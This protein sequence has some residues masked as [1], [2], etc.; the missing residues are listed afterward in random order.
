MWLFCKSGFFSAVRHQT[1][2]DV[3]HVRARFKGD[4][5]RLLTDYAE[6]VAGLPKPSAVAHTPRA[7]YAYR[8][9]VPAAA[10]TNLVAAVAADIDYTNFKYAAHDGTAR[11]DAYFEVWNAMKTA[12]VNCAAEEILQAAEAEIERRLCLMREAGV[13]T[14]ADLKLPPKIFELRD[15]FLLTEKMWKRMENV[16]LK[17]R[18]AWVAVN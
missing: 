2:A 12:Q 4:L 18:P 13:R 6:R 5:E 1:R 8:C 16:Q 7:D 9:D 10:W 17:G 15:A 14:A 3:I 11:D